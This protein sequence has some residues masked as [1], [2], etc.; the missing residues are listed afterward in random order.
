MIAVLQPHI[1]HYR[2][3]FFKGLNDYSSTKVYCYVSTESAER[4]NFKKADVE[5]IFLKSYSIG[6]FMWYDLNPFLSKKVNTLV[7][8]LDLKTV[9]MF[10][11]KILEK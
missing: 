2:E 1:P 3:A 11:I 10:F 9:N 7:L 4:D 6:P 8:M 5:T